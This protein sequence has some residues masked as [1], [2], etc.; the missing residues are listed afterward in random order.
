[1]FKDLNHFNDP[2]CGRAF[3][4]TGHQH[5]DRPWM[6]WMIAGKAF[7]GGHH[8]RHTAFHVCSTTTIKNAIDDRG[9]KRGV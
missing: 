4:I 7:E 1:M 5:S 2:I 8:R 6:V 9:F 3:F